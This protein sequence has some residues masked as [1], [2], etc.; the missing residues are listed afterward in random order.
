[1]DGLPTFVPSQ[2]WKYICKALARRKTFLAGAGMGILHLI[3]LSGF[4]EDCKA[5]T[6]QFLRR[7]ETV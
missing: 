2:P 5:P 3:Y 7:H 6:G 1:M 4:A